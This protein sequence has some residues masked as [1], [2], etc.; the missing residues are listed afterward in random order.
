MS[1]YTKVKCN[2]HRL[3]PSKFPPVQLFDW[4]ETKDELEQIAALEGLTSNR[5]KTELGDIN[6]VPKDEWVGG[7][8]SSPIMAAFTNIGYPSRFSD[9]TFGVFYAADSIDAAIRETMF[10]RE[11]LYTAS[12]EAPCP[13]SMREYIAKTAEPLI[14]IK[15]ETHGECLNPDIQSYEKSQ[16][17]SLNLRKE[18]AWGIHYPSMRSKGDHCV[19]ILRPKAIAVPVIQGAHYRYLWDGT[20]ISDVYKE[21]KVKNIER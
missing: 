14:Q 10:H 5:L 6:L 8:G 21:S 12:N 17:F 20:S 2:V 4:A 13:I 11:R 15:R 9:G 19:A 18:Q 7:E 16:Q 1:V 3:I